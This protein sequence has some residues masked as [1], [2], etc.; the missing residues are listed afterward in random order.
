MYIGQI[1]RT[2]LV[3]VPPETTLVEARELIERHRIG[4]LLVVDGKGRLAGI[5]SDRD[6]RLNWAS[7]ATT[8][9]VHELHYLLPKVELGAIMVDNVITVTPDTTIER[10][11]HIM[12]TQVI[13][14]LPVMAAGRLVGIVTRTD[15]MGV[16][17][18]AI[19]MG[20]ESRRLG[21][22]VDDRIGRLAEV[23]AILRDQRINIQSLF[24]W[25]VTG[26]PDIS[27]L[28]IR[29]AASDGEQAI[30]A[31][32]AGGFKV[33]TRYER[34]LRPFLPRIPAAQPPVADHGPGKK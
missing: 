6:L 30:A 27:H 33:L 7:P 28:V 11:A 3:T 16:L 19:G 8:L 21:V 9:S 18:Q 10:A 31:L 29:V 12:Q 14:S 4:H 13:S 2:D 25:P 5:V 24:C 22:L 20:G 17:L 15:V 1:M 32:E 34:D 23:T 26:F